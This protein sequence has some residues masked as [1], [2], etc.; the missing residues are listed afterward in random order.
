MGARRAPAAQAT[1][2]GGRARAG[3][4]RRPCRAER[5]FMDS[6]LRRPLERLTGA[7]SFVSDLPSALSALGAGWPVGARPAGPCGRL[8]GAG[9][10][11]PERMFHRW[12][13]H[14]RQTGGRAVGKPKRGKG[15]KLMAGA[16]RP[17]LPLAVRTECA[18]PHA[19]PLVAAP[20]AARLVAALPARLIG[21]RAYDSAP[22]AACLREWGIDLIAPHRPNRKKPPTQAGRSLRRYKRRWKV[23][24]LFAW[25]GNFRRLVVRY[26]YQAAN[27]LGF[28]QLACIV[29]LLRQYF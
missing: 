2:P 23:E 21:A 17:G 19:V 1:K 3:A 24:R 15:T 26:E 14:R 28:V 22:L 18:P 13:V 29:I 25:L 7:L 20:L 12:H 6:A 10:P 4:L 27:Y 9:R 11:G 16:A 5:A 8:A